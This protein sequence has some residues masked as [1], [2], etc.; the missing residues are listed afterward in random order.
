MV[1]NPLTPFL[2]N[3][4]TLVLDGGLATELERNGY[5]LGDALWSARLLA[6]A[7]QAIR[8]VHLDYLE[9]GADCIISASY[10]ATI[11]GF[12]GR[13]MTETAAIGL[14]EMSVQIAVEARD[15]FW[16]EPEK[17]SGRIR[18]IVATSIGPYGAALADGS[19]YTGEYDLDP[20]GLHDFHHK[21]WHILAASGADILAC[22]TIPSF[23]ESRALSRLLRET[24][25]RPAWFSFSCR[26]GQ[27]IADGT[28]L[29]DCIIPL[30]NLEQVVAVGINC[31]APHHIPGLLAIA[32]QATDK[33]IIVYPNSGEQFDPENKRWLGESVPA[34]FGTFS[35][36]WR[37]LGATLIGGCCRTRPDH[38]R[39]IRDRMDRKKQRDYP[40][41]L[42][43]Q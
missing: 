11:D 22:E 32:R 15:A 25:D 35:R 33:A 38:I 26:D 17:R 29:R 20:A 31:T 39:Q 4:G 21:R 28:P 18:P 8:Q 42:P 13:G 6:D 23:P 14:I 16:A 2:A 37:K 5:D 36:E 19:E 43:S 9:A 40:N 30:N 7:P 1:K 41:P 34:E 12:M 3:N 10:Q 24:P 27:H